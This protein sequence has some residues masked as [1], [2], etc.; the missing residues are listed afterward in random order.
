MLCFT[1]GQQ[2]IVVTDT[3]F[4]W[5]LILANDMLQYPTIEVQHCVECVSHKVLT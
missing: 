4:C 3:N 1:D 2:R 5:A